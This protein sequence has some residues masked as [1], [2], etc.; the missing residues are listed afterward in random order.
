MFYP[1]KHWDN[2]NYCDREL[3]YAIL[4]MLFRAVGLVP[5]NFNLDCAWPMCYLEKK[6]LLILCR[7]WQKSG[8]ATTP[9][10]RAIRLTTSL[11]RCR[12]RPMHW[13]ANYSVAENRR[14]TGPGPDF[15]GFINLTNGRRRSV[16]AYGSGFFG[17]TLK[18]RSNLVSLQLHRLP[19]VSSFKSRRQY[20]VLKGLNRRTL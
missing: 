1:L 13:L 12:W 20:W 5:K 6:I 14:R 17:K 18:S 7:V 9:F 2:I 15:S 4:L 3:L 16:L 8:R 11:C 19:L 10:K